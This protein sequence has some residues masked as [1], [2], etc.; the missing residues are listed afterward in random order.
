VP[1]LPSF[2]IFSQSFLFAIPAF[3]VPCFSILLTFI[4]P[5]KSSS[6]VYLLFQ[7]ALLPFLLVYDTIVVKVWGM[8]AKDVVGDVVSTFSAGSLL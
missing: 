7:I 3:N 4:F 1:W 2:P 5:F 6:I 8:A